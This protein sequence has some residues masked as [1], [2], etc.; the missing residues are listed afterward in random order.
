MENLPAGGDCYE[1]AL[2]L[3]YSLLMAENSKLVHGRVHGQGPLTGYT[4]GHAW[5]ELND[6]VL[7]FSNGG[8]LIT[9]KEEYYAAGKISETIKYG[10][11]EILDHVEKTRHSGPW[12]ERFFEVG[13]SASA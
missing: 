1:A 11:D 10:W 7:D 2:D 13:I 5:V 12:D 4:F 8:S 3:F 6:F 9:N